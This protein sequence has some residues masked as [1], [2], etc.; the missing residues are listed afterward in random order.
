MELELRLKHSITLPASERPGD[1]RNVTSVIFVKDRGELYAG[2]ENGSIV[3]WRRTQIAAAG[4]AT[5]SLKGHKGT[6]KC[7]HYT[8]QLRL[9][10]SASAD[11]AV[12]AWDIVNGDSCIQ[13]MAG[14]GGGVNSVSY[15]NKWL[16]TGSTD[17]TVKLWYADDGAGVLLHP[18][19]VAVQTLQ[20]E[21]DCWVTAVAFHGSVATHQQTE[22]ETVSA[23][24]VIGLGNGHLQLYTQSGQ[25]WVLEANHKTHRLAAT[26]VEYARQDGVFFSIGNDQ[27]LYGVQAKSGLRFFAV[28]NPHRCKF[29][30]LVWMRGAK[31]LVTVDQIGN[32]YIHDPFTDT[33]LAEQQVAQEP[34]LSVEALTNADLMLCTIHKAMFWTIVREVP[35]KEYRGHEGP[36]LTVQYVHPLGAAQ[37]DV[38]QLY[39]AALD[40]TLVV[41]DVPDM[42]PRSNITAH[43]S[44]I[45]AMRYSQVNHQIITG[46]ENGSVRFWRPD[47]KNFYEVRHHSNTVTCIALATLKK[48]E[49]M[50]TGDYNGVVNLWDATVNYRSRPHANVTIQAS[51]K[52][53]LCVCYHIGDMDNRTDSVFTAGNDCKIQR[54]HAASGKHIGT[55]VGHTDAVTTLMV[56][57]NFLFSGSE[58]H[59][60]RIWDLVSMDELRV[61]KAHT[62]VVRDILQLPGGSFVSG[63]ADGRVC[64][65]KAAVREPLVT[66]NFEGELC[67]FTY[68]RSRHAVIAGTTEGSLVVMPLPSEAQLQLSRE[69]LMTAPV[70]AR[71][72]SSEDTTYKNR[73][74]GPELQWDEALLGNAEDVTL[75]DTIIDPTF[76]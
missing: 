54:W 23:E 43:G 46:H 31:E 52:E 45:T 22:Q 13:T 20:M 71:T 70:T 63:G 62:A 18:W 2:S 28:Q 60:V 6:I 64:L 73:R 9:L 49:V 17:G 21:T 50:V 5:L 51:E 15:L 34:L 59:T 75:V 7:L 72:S 48:W 36:V 14:H 35:F 67:T 74:R 16:A 25:T 37:T 42:Q 33:M 30:G 26:S 76:A 27:I 12:R 61:L 56:D 44:E 19:F 38:P 29:S 47:L 39:S 66:L 57:T 11:R 65:W 1:G 68:H 41:W 24:L 8:P 69:N 55:L 4:Q 58:D 10:F 40:N 53:V 32:C 3:G